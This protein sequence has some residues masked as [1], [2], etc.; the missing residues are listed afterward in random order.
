MVRLRALP[1]HWYRWRGR[2]RIERSRT[3]PWIT[4][5]DPSQSLAQLLKASLQTVRR[6]TKSVH[7]GSVLENMLRCNCLYACYDKTTPYFPAWGGHFAA[8]NRQLKAVWQH[9]LRHLQDLFDGC[10]PDQLLVPADKGSNSRQR[11]FLCAARSGILSIRCS[12]ADSSCDTV[13]R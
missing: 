3:E 2:V 11:V 6:R 8:C 9:S 7:T 10:F 4:M 5:A 13:A 1:A 12:N